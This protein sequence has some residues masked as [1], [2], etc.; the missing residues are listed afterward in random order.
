MSSAPAVG[1]RDR[2]PRPARGVLLDA[3]GQP[4]RGPGRP[5]ASGGGAA[6]S[7]ETSS[8]RKL[9]TAPSISPPAA[10]TRS[11]CSA[12]P[13]GLAAAASS[14]RDVHRRLGLGPQ[15]HLQPPP[16]LL[17]AAGQVHLGHVRVGIQRRQGQVLLG[18]QRVQAGSPRSSL[19]S[20]ARTP[21]PAAAGPC[22]GPGRSAAPAR[23]GSRAGRR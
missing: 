11:R 16:Q 23:P 3:L 20:P 9:N 12:E 1:Q 2:Q 15:Q 10:A 17:D 4:A 13:L 7:C 5:A 6:W 22:G 18:R 8:P 19:R 21:A 14:S